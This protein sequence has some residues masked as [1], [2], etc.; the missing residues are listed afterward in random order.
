MLLV[1]DQR[2]TGAATMDGL[3][4]L[5]LL[6]Q[7]S[8]VHDRFQAHELE[9]AVKGDVNYRITS[10]DGTVH[11]KTLDAEGLRFGIGVHQKGHL[12]DGVLHLF[13]QANACSLKTWL[14]KH[15]PYDAEMRLEQ[16]ALLWFAERPHHHVFESRNQVNNF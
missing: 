11:C 13:F 2:R 15:L 9:L 6:L 14:R 10:V 7:G 16:H 12:P 1:V 4:D 5:E 3:G 8:Q